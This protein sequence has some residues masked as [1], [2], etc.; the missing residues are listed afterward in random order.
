MIEAAL[1]DLEAR[2]GVTA[3]TGLQISSPE[4]LARRPF[5]PG[6]ALMILSEG[7]AATTYDRGPAE[8]LADTPA[9]LDEAAAFAGPARPKRPPSGGCG[10][11]RRPLSR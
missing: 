1:R 11:A 2:F 6:W 4:S 8:L 5:D 7:A 9:L 10:R 3:A